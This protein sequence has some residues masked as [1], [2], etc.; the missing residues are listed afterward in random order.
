MIRSE[1]WRVGFDSR[2]AK[3]ETGNPKPTCQ[4]GFGQPKAESRN[5]KPETD[6]ST[7]LRTAETRKPK[8][9]TDL[10]PTSRIALRIETRDDFPFTLFLFDDMCDLFAQRVVLAKWF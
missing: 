6:L 3:L 10:N 1:V 7:W 4:L 5:P 2:N 9:E 8:P